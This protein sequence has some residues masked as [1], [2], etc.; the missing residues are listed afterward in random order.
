MGLT[1]A[2]AHSSLRFSLGLYT[3][4]S[5][6]DQVLETLARQVPKARAAAA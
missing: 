6:V 3:T 5:E 2:Q 1:S 4:E